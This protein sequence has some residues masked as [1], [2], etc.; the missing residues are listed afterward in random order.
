MDK[1]DEKIADEVLSRDYE[2]TIFLSTDG[3]HTVSTVSNNPEAHKRAVLAA[4]ELYDQIVKK[5][6]TK[7]AQAVKAYSA[8]PSFPD[9]SGSMA[10][11]AS[12]GIPIC[13]IHHNPMKLRTGKFGDFWSC[14]MKMDDGSWCKYKPQ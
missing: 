2:L 10:H 5:Y 3:K 9:D 8:K 11:E 4:T 12:S 13:P 7:Q 1:D 6:G 14:G